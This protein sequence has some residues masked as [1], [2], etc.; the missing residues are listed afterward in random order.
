ML[1]YTY[2]LDSYG[3]VIRGFYFDMENNVP[4]PLLFTT[5]EVI[6]SIKNIEKS[7]SSIGKN[8]KSFIKHSV[9]WKKVMLVGRL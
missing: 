4:G 2:D 6:D 9:H 7:M 1:F 8:M 3:D 5:E